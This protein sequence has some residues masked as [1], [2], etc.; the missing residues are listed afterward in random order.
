VKIAFVITGLGVGGAEQQLLKIAD[1]MVQMRWSIDVY[2]FDG[3]T[4]MP[5]RLRKAGVTVEVAPYEGVLKYVQRMRWLKHKLSEN[6]PDCIVAFMLQANV[7]ARL[8]GKALNVPTIASIRNSRFGGNSRIGQFIGDA[9]ERSTRRLGFT[10]VVNSRFAACELVRRRVLKKQDVTVITNGLELTALP[11]LPENQSRPFRWLSAGRLVP[12]KNYGQL[13]EA[14]ALLM[15]RG[16]KAEL[17]IAGEGPLEADLKTLADSLSIAANVHFLG[18]HSNVQELMKSMDGFVLAS[19][20]EGLPN[21]IMEAMVMGLPVTA[22]NVGGVGEL[23][24]ENQ[25]GF[26]VA[27]N[28]LAMLAAKMAELMNA[29]TDIRENLV[30]NAYVHIKEHFSLDKTVDQWRQLILSAVQ[31]QGPKS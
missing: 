23:I 27:P 5:A 19:L 28:Q 16:E 10:T 7:T 18:L 21:V 15:A 29:D 22:T 8:V 9:L 1:R 26:L 20:W 31:S 13:L 4:E 25:T 3:G 2:A 24:V 12:Q 17:Y 14:F 11:L 30:T 6:R